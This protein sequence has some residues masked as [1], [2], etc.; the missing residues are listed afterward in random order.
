LTFKRSG[1]GCYLRSTRTIRAP[2][3]DGLRGGF[4]PVVRRVFRVFLRAFR[5][6][7][8]A[9]GFLLHGVRGWSVLE[10][11]TVRDGADGPQAH[12]R[13]S[14]IEGAVLEVRG[15]F[16]DRPSQTHRQSA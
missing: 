2:L 13:W 8:F 6:I 9:G 5:S 3:T 12:H 10:C 1:S 11:R 4:Q 7:H 16:W 14:F 15:L